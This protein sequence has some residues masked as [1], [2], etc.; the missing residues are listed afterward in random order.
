[1]VALSLRWLSIWRRK[2]SESSTF[3]IEPIF[4]CG[5]G[6][7]STLLFLRSSASC[8]S[9]TLVCLRVVG[10]ARLCVCAPIFLISFSIFWRFFRFL[11]VSQDMDGLNSD[12]LQYIAS[13][14][15]ATAIKLGLICKRFREAVED[16][17]GKAFETRSRL[18]AMPPSRSAPTPTISPPPSA[19]VPLRR[20]E[21]RRT[22]P[23]RQVCTRP[24][25]RRG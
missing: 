11:G 3:K 6:C 10:I 24:P 7:F 2:S 19:Q 22:A 8:S 16:G 4:V 17:E 20:Q 5:S 13:M 21:H 12:V 23:G 18:V 25:G 9:A 15:V 1:M 14:G